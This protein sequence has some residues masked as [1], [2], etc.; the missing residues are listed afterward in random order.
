M[1]IH[2]PI[3]QQKNNISK[4]QDIIN[5]YPNKES[6]EYIKKQQKEFEKI[7]QSL[8]DNYKDQFIYFENGEIL[9]SDL[10]EEELVKRVMEKVGY[11]SV[12]ITKV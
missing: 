8:L 3:I 6:F 2:K 5:L 4:V 10:I 9:D 1:I 12:F 7:D 11:R